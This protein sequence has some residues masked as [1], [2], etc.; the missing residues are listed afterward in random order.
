MFALRETLVL[1]TLKPQK[2][3]KK[4]APKITEKV[5]SKN[6]KFEA[7]HFPFKKKK[8]I[9]VSCS[10]GVAT[11]LQ[12]PIDFGG[13]WT[14]WT[15][16]PKTQQS[17]TEN[18]KTKSVREFWV[19]LGTKLVGARKEDEEEDMEVATKKLWETDMFFFFLMFGFW[20]FRTTK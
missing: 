15:L 10:W 1:K 2:K 19:Y 12:I 8:S 18:K 9:P 11:H 20:W 3:K 17:M 6:P 5:F 14:V 13:N 4:L 7:F 16:Y